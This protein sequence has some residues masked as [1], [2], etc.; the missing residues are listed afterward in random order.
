MTNLAYIDN[1]AFAKKGETLAEALPIKHFIRLAELLGYPELATLD[2]STDEVK[3][4]LKGVSNGLSQYYLLLNIEANLT[5]LCQ[6]CLKP[7]T[8]DVSINFRYL[9]SDIDAHTVEELDDVDLLQIE[10]AMD[11]IT[12]VEDELIAALPIAP[13]HTEGCELKHNVSGEKPN[14]FAVLKNLIKTPN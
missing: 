9:L 1:L 11:V 14:P 4:T 12:L 10:Q 7:A 8:L 5:A 2:N 13:T 6:R 3:F